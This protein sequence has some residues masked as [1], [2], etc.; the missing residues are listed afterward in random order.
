MENAGKVE[1]AEKAP[2]PDSVE[3]YDPM[4]TATMYQCYWCKRWAT[5]DRWIPLVRCPWCQRMAPTGEA[6][7]GFENFK[8]AP[9]WQSHPS[10]YLDR[11]FR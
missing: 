7:Q 4:I 10:W 8:N 5:K 2:Q 11:N 1:G 3:L 6:F 9:A